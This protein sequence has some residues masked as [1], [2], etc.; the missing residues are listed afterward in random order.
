[1]FGYA[2]RLMAMSNDKW[3]RDDHLVARSNVALSGIILRAFRY[4][5]G[6]NLTPSIDLLRSILTKLAKA[7]VILLALRAGTVAAKDPEAEARVFALWIVTT[8]LLSPSAWAHYLVLLLLAFAVLVR[9]W[10]RGDVS[11]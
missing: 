1:T 6:E 3:L 10:N 5:A 4:A 11:R 2:G 9:A 7:I 8:V